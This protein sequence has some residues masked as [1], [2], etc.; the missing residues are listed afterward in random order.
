MES[1]SWLNIVLVFALLVTSLPIWNSTLVKAVGA[2]Q[3]AV[4]V[5]HPVKKIKDYEVN[6]DIR[7][8]YLPEENK[9]RLENYKGPLSKIYKYKPEITYKT[10]AYDSIFTRFPNLKAIV[11]E[12]AGIGNKITKIEF[13][14]GNEVVQTQIVNSQTFKANVPLKPEKVPVISKDNKSPSGAYI[15]FK[16]VGKK[17]V[18][19]Y[20]SNWMEEDKSKR[21]TPTKMNSGIDAY[22]GTYFTH[23]AKFVRQKS[24]YNERYKDV[25]KF[26]E[27]W[28]DENPTLLNQLNA[29]AATD[30]PKRVEVE[31][32]RNNI[33]FPYYGNIMIDGQTYQNTWEK[34]LKV[35]SLGHAEIYF[36]QHYKS[37]GY[38]EPGKYLM[39]YNS[40]YMY[41]IRAQSYRYPDRIRV[42]TTKG[43]GDTPKDPKCTEERGQEVSGKD[44][45][46]NVSAV[47]LADQRG[48]E[49]F[50]V[51]QGIPTSE[52]LYGN[53][54]AKNYL[55]QNKFVQMTGKCIFEVT[56]N[57]TFTLQWQETTT[58]TD[59]NGNSI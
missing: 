24:Y 52:S 44:L 5:A 54:F 12:D 6:G 10:D 55:Y 23:L 39:V 28:I 1:R 26:F 49:Q 42:Y 16:L 27:E 4:E 20:T 14:K 3:E 36:S 53:V 47:I 2:N 32:E 43:K 19:W 41:T 15:A 40:S 51:L 58:V 38:Y 9:F 17:W 21:V 31:Y 8:E 46:P 35:T 34:D 18:M 29:G 37:K 33:H 50:N 45:D 22:P 57:K 25:G 7:R 48:S 11:N 59:A 13:L 56:V 30:N